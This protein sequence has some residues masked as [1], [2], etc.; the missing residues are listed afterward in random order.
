MM[1]EIKPKIDK[2]IS[3]YKSELGKMQSDFNRARGFK[4][5]LYMI[6]MTKIFRNFIADITE[7]VREESE[8]IV[9]ITNIT[10]TKKYI[11]R[12]VEYYKDVVENFVFKNYSEFA[13]EKKNITN[14]FKNACKQQKQELRNAIDDGILSIKNNLSNYR[15]GQWRKLLSNLFKKLLIGLLSLEGLVTYFHKIFS[16]IL[17][18]LKI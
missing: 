14:S 18:Y 3:E 13:K 10:V 7:I 12:I 15:K 5:G 17:N 2:T 6:E 1:I 16:G 9:R 11:L 8:K 4:N